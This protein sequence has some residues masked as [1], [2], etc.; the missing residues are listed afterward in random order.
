MA[1]SVIEGRLCLW[2]S[3]LP[4]IHWRLEQVLREFSRVVRILWDFEGCENKCEVGR[5]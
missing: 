2:G 4:S 3:S 5:Q 1:G